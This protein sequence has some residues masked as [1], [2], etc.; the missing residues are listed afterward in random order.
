MLSSILELSQF[1]GARCAAGD[2]VLDVGVVKGP[3]SDL[4]Q[5]FSSRTANAVWIGISLFHMAVPCQQQLRF[6]RVHVFRKVPG[7]VALLNLIPL[8]SHPLRRL[9]AA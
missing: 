7:S 4:H 9:F 6:S 5:Y 1:P 3:G 8:F 2:M